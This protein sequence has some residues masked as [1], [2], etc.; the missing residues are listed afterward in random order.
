VTAVSV[1]AG[2]QSIEGLPGPVLEARGE[3]VAGCADMLPNGGCAR[4]ARG[5]P[6]T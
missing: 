5:A 6:T 3:R 2:D 4:P 1:A